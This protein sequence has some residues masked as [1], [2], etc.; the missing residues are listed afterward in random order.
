MKKL[1]KILA[2]SLAAVIA[3]STMSFSV[4]AASPSSQDEE[5][6]Y[7]TQTDSEGNIIKTIPWREQ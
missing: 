1:K 6:V 5:T 4:F 2:I 7:F 3:I